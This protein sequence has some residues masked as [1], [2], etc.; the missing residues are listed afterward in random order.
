MEKYKLISIVLLV[1]CML[2]TAGRNT[3]KGATKEIKVEI[4]T[5]EGSGITEADVNDWI[6]KT[7]EVDKPQVKFIVTSRH[8]YAPNSVYDVNSNDPC[9]INIWG[10]STNPWAAS[11]PDILDPNVSAQW[12]SVII[13]VPGDGNDIYI[14]DSTLAHELNHIIAKSSEKQGSQ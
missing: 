7:N 3:A 2:L 1:L 11:Y 13:L 6:D 14:K 5:V 12:G 9:R 8:T 4:H 10:I